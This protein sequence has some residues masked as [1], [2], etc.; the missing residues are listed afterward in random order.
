MWRVTIMRFRGWWG[1]DDLFRLMACILYLITKSLT[2]FFSLKYAVVCSYDF[3][4]NTEY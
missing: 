4:A 2:Y 1:D 3:P